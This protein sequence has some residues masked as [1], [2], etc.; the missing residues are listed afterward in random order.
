LNIALIGH[1]GE[2]R[3]RRE[4]NI[5]ADPPHI[6]HLVDAG[7]SRTGHYLVLEHVDGQNIDRNSTS[8]R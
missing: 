1:A 3:F 4:G 7:V 2:D 6:A 5:L 8:T